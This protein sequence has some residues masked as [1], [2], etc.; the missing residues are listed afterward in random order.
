M[1]L[2]KTLKKI[3]SKIL[4][5]KQELTHED[6]LRIEEKSAAYLNKKFVVNMMAVITLLIV[7]TIAFGSVES[8]LQAVQAKLVGT[9]LP[10]AAICGLCIAGMSFV[11]GHAN[12][13]QH[14]IYAVVGAIVGFGA[15]SIVSLIRGVIH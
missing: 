2:I 7:P 6:F 12:A 8:S 10:L 4:K 13:R 15:E 5:P 1:E 11:M 3:F 14:L 9:L